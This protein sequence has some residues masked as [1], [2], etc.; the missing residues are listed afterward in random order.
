MSLTVN[1]LISLAESKN[2]DLVEKFL[3]SYDRS[4]HIDTGNKTGQTLLIMA[5]KNGKTKLVKSLINLGAN[6]DA[7]TNGG[8]TALMKAAYN[9][10]TETTQ[11]LVGVGANPDLQTKSDHTALMLTV[12]NK[13]TNVPKS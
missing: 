2:F 8:Y 9:G 5:A 4:L 7:K 13:N 1:D 12:F 6:I 11:L 3:H 10:H